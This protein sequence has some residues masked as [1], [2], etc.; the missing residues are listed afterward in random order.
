MDQ[1]CPKVRSGGLVRIVWVLL[2]SLCIHLLIALG[3]LQVPADWAQHAITPPLAEIDLIEKPAPSKTA[4]DRLVVRQ[5]QIPNHFRDEDLKDK[6]RF[7][8]EDDQRVLQETRA[9]RTGLTRNGHALPPD[10]WMK[11]MPT[12][13]TQTSARTR[14]PAFEDRGGPMPIQLPKPQDL[15]PVPMFDDAPSAVGE[16]LPDDVSIGELTAL[17]TDRFKYYSFYSR[18][19]E[20]VRFRWES[21][22]QRAINAFDRGYLTKVIGRRNWI[23]RIE[24]WISPEGRYLSAHIYKEAGVRAFDLAAVSAFREAGVFPNPP[25]EMIDKDG[26]IRLQYTFNVHWNPSFLSTAD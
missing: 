18:V 22:L 4:D 12:P 2:A 6:A 25:A 21:A 26:V 19:E 5:T 10:S 8:S 3:L 7:L 20:L 11:T 14:G 17:N 24:F 16:R 23:T 15:P 13:R 1:D 9:R